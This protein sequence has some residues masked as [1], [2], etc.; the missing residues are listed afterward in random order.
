[1]TELIHKPIADFVLRLPL[2]V[3]FIFLTIVSVLFVAD[4]VK[5]TKEALDLGRALEAMT[6]LKAEAEEM[7]VQ[8]ALLKA[9]DLENFGRKPLPEQIGFTKRQPFW[10]VLPI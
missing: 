2:I 5:S 10:T 7:Q 1:M 3:E 4:A 8:I 9:C 6:K